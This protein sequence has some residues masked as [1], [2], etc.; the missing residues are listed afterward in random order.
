MIYREIAF[1]MDR[2]EV[3]NGELHEVSDDPMLVFE[4]KTI[5]RAS[6]S[7]ATRGVRLAEKYTERTS[8]ESQQFSES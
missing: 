8:Y 6:L 7:R 5:I 4:G 1:D 3:T 2:Q